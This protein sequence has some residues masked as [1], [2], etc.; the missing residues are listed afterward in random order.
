MTVQAQD[1]QTQDLKR[2]QTRNLP[3]AGQVGSEPA[4]VVMLAI[5]S[6]SVTDPPRFSGGSEEHVHVLAEAQAELPPII[7]HRATMR[8]IDGAHRLRAAKVRGDQEIAARFFSGNAADAFVLSVKSNIKHGLPLSLAERMAAAERIIKSHPQWS[9]RMIASVTGLASRTIADVRARQTGDAVQVTARIGQDGR[10]RPVDGARGRVLASKI[11]SD[12]PELSLRQVAQAAGISPETVRDVRNRLRR[13]EDPVPSRYDRKRSEQNTQSA[14]P[15]VPPE[16]PPLSQERP[17]P[18]LERQVKSE[19]PRLVSGA[20]PG[21]G[22]AAAVSATAVM[23]RL[24]ADP[25][26][27]LTETGRILL[28]LLHAH[29]VETEKWDRIVENVPAHCGGII[30]QLARECAQLW[31]GFA[32]QVERNVMNVS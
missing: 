31:E 26:L 18:K 29:L 14:G 10:I 24:R 5:S 30:A 11:L 1:L 23:E 15:A 27:R 20:H 22:R 19:C 8:V 7:V 2:T 25:A 16:R 28:R 21:T 32:D 4:P 13:G 6:L 9:D 17:L 3:A 12:N